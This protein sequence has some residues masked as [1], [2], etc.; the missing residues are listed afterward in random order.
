[1]VKQHVWIK[2]LGMAMGLGLLLVMGVRLSVLA[3]V[4][5]AMPPIDG[6]TAAGTGEVHQAGDSMAFTLG[7]TLYYAGGWVGNNPNN[8][9]VDV[10]MLDLATPESAWV[11]SSPLD[12]GRFGSAVATHNGYAYLLGGY[13]SGYLQT[14]SKF[15][16]SV[17]FPAGDLPDGAR[18]F[19]AATTLMMDGK[20][21]LYIAG[22]LPGPTDQVWRSPIENGELVGWLRQPV[23]PQE[24]S[25]L[26]LVSYQNCL[27]AVGGKDALGQPHAEIYAA[28]VGN[29]GQVGAWNQVDYINRSQSTPLAFSG[30][31]IHHNKLYILGGETPGN[32]YSNQGFSVTVN[33]DCT[34]GN[35]WQTFAMPGAPAEGLRRMAVAARWGDIYGEL[36]IIGGQTAN[37][38]SDAAW[39]TTLP[40]PDPDLTLRKSAQVQDGEFDYGQL[41][42]YTLAY[43]N[44][45][46]N[47]KGHTNVTIT[48]TV[49][50]STTFVSASSDITPTGEG[51]LS[52]PIGNLAPEESGEASFTVQVDTSNL[53]WTLSGDITVTGEITRGQDPQSSIMLGPEVISTLAYAP[54]GTVRTTEGIILATTVPTQ[55]FPVTVTGTAGALLEY[56]YQPRPPQV[57]VRVPGP[58]TQPGYITITY[59][60]SET[61]TPKAMSPLW[62]ELSDVMYQTQTAELAFTQEGYTVPVTC[63]PPSTMLL[64]S[65]PKSISSIAPDIIIRNQAWICSDELPGCQASN[66]TVTRYWPYQIYLPLTLRNIE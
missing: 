6:W 32:G 61:F 10:K 33:A 54:T 28:P 41:I 19:F 45:W 34:L 44:P 37:G 24:L 51:L 43:H 48:D 20:A 36:Y 21:Y 66:E 4:L 42:T 56:A 30:V 7:D 63:S 25:G 22:G 39:R 1:M 26:G 47:P 38:Y 55:I 17:W 13:N 2:N 31:V 53:A 29:G 15:D 59:C 57:L 16:G 35:D 8:P 18:A 50:V 9:S 40:T 12:S 3:E 23:L 64:N 65:H 11:A 46:E 62:I 49:P 5:L 60:I 58:I 27:F 52:W 14:I